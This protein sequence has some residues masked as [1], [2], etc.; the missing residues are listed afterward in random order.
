[1]YCIISNVCIFVCF[2]LIDYT[3]VTSLQSNHAN[4]CCY[5]PSSSRTGFSNRSF[6]YWCI[7]TIMNMRINYT[8]QNIFVVCVYDSVSTNIFYCLIE[9]FYSSI[10]NQNIGINNTIKGNNC[11]YIFDDNVAS[12]I[13]NPLNMAINI[14]LILCNLELVLKI[15]Q[16]APFSKVSSNWLNYSIQINGNRI[17]KIFG[18]NFFLV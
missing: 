16:N 6:I 2:K 13:Q 7:D 8:W 11:F 5:P 3:F 18:M 1:M 9:C 4:Y 14:N 10:F 17:L 12:T 15:I